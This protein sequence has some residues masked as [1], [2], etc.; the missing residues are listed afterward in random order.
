LEISTELARENPGYRGMVG[1]QKYSLGRLL[2]DRGKPEEGVVA[3]RDALKIQDE[4]W[5]NHTMMRP[6][7]AKLL[8][9]TGHTEEAEEV[10]RSSLAIKQKLLADFP[11]LPHHH[12]DV[13]EV[14][15]SLGNLLAEKG[16][17]L[18]AEQ[19][20]RHAIDV[21]EPVFAKRQRPGASGLFECYNSLARLLKETQ[22]TEE[23]E[24]IHRR[25]IAFY[26]KQAAEHAEVPGPQ[27]DLAWRYVMLCEFY[28]DTGQPIKA[29]EPYRQVAG[30]CEELLA[31]FPDDPKCH[32]QW[33][34]IRLQLIKHLKATGQADELEELHRQTIAIQ[35]RIG[36]SLTATH[37]AF[38]DKLQR[39][40]DE[41]RNS[42]NELEDVDKRSA[43]DKRYQSSVTNL[44]EWAL[45]QLDELME[46][47]PANSV[48]WAARGR[49]KTRLKDWGEA[50][51]D[52]A[53]AIELAPKEASYWN[54]LGTAQYR[55]GDWN[56][57][58]NALT[59][60][61][62][63]AVGGNS[64][65]WYFLAMANW[66]LGRTEEARTWY[67]KAVAWTDQN[68]PGDEELI[69]FRTEAAELLGVDTE[70]NR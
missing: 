54:M 29:G 28:R 8:N 62:E 55:A 69:R 25:A 40:D 4:F 24:Q 39:L 31:E 42:L 67:D 33:R 27:Y 37:D 47:E 26:A 14:E 7:L 60:S 50:A 17:V 70:S 32:W 63:L 3:L 38:D 15:R 5:N 64:L 48:H 11:D 12:F 18:E 58:I 46:A 57:A 49:L 41:Y 65:D 56:A 10:Y 52:F 53:K 1:A 44:I 61:M 45:T 51:T 66:Q 20:Y 6:E 21:F 35:E 59:K 30:V 23:A 43:I 13:A 19:L 9:K 2:G 34:Q 36:N 68:R 16:Q 22:R